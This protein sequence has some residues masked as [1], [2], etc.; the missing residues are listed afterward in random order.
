[1]KCNIS[2]LLPS[3]LLLL[4]LLQHLQLQLQLHWPSAQ[5]PCTKVSNQ[6]RLKYDLT[7]ARYAKYTYYMYDNVYVYTIFICQIAYV[8]YSMRH[9]LASDAPSHSPS[10][11]LSLARFH[12]GISLLFPYLTRAP[13]HQIFR[14]KPS[15]VACIAFLSKRLHSQAIVPHKVGERERQRNKGS[16]SDA[17][18]NAY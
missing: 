9:A 6:N 15:I 5:I 14:R 3:L 2:M 8:A 17:L 11:A 4:L 7:A 13:S 12:F 1:M 16:G 18:A 10:P